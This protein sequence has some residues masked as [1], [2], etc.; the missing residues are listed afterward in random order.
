P[1]S[2]TRYIPFQYS[3]KYRAEKSSELT[4]G[5]LRVTIFIDQS[6]GADPDVVFGD[7]FSISRQDGGLG[8]ADVA[9]PTLLQ[10]T[11]DDRS[12]QPAT[13]DRLNTLVNT[14][15]GIPVSMTALPG[16]TDPNSGIDITGNG[17]TYIDSSSGFSIVRVVYDDTQC[18]GAGIFTFDVNG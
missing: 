2:N 7:L 15:F 4:G 11:Y 16:E 5:G 8:E 1:C 10:V 9:D 6:A 17:I 13:A 14:D 3:L 12:G 18:N